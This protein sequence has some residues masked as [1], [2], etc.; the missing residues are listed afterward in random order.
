ML[1]KDVFAV[2]CKSDVA[3]FVNLLSI[4]D[5]E[6]FPVVCNALV[7][8]PVGSGNDTAEIGCVAGKLFIV[9]SFLLKLVLSLVIVGFAIK[10][11]PFLD[12]VVL[13]T[14]VE[15]GKLEIVINFLDKVLLSFVIVD[16]NVPEPDELV[17][18]NALYAKQLSYI[19]LAV[20]G[21]GTPCTKNKFI[22][23]K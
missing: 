5:K 4:E 8:A 19:E 23:L 11:T 16:E 13:S 14:V 18:V 2:V 12:A 7:V 17:F 3:T 9:I 1:F 15:V 21:A 10:T 20:I 22:F 6:L